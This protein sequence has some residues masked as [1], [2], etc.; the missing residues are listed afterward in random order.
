MMNIFIMIL[1][2]LFM[3]AFYMMAS[4]NMRI[5]K[6]ET[7]NAVRSADLLSVAECAA[8][9]HSATIRGDVL[10]DVCVER[11]EIVS[12]RVCLSSNLAVTDCKPARN[13]KPA[14]SYIVTA[15]AP[16]P[17]DIYSDMMDILEE[18]YADA[19]TFGIF[20]ENTI[21]SGASANKR[22]VPKGIISDMKLTDGAL[23]YLTQYE[24]TDAQTEYATDT[25]T[26]LRCPAGTT[27]TYRFGRWQCVG[28]NTKSDCP[29]DTVWDSDAL[30]CIADESRKPLCAERQTAVLVED[31]WEC[32]DPFPEKKCPDD[33]IARLNYQTLEWECV[34]D[35]QKTQDEKKCKRFTGNAVYGAVGTT[36]RVPTSSCTDCERMITDE[37][38]CTAVCVPDPAKINSPQCYPGGAKSCSGP[39]HAF[40]FGFPSRAYAAQVEAISNIDVPFEKLPSQNRRFNCLECAGGEI[41]AAKSFPP[42]IAVCK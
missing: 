35:P 10:D 12:H 31:V 8:G 25:D 36:L 3:G 37:E 24:I 32:I 42:Y 40:Y 18:H 13:K 1:V 2:T 26:D 6:H 30:E 34:K 17:D 5:A 41:D 28:L 22:I 38:T 9:V 11:N 20:Q 7:E 33:M 16:L 23:V 14:Y 39:S 15:T 19:G 21:V 29:G 27:K 4:P